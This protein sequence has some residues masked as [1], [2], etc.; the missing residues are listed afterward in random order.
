MLESKTSA[1][2]IQEPPSFNFLFEHPIG[3]TVS[4]EVI[5]LL[6]VHGNNHVRSRSTSP[7]E[8]KGKKEG[9]EFLHKSMGF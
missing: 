2:V 8:K 6:L 7:K 4:L 3:N 1:P 9:Q 5:L